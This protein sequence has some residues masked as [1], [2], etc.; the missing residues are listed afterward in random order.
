MLCIFESISRDLESCPRD[1]EDGKQGALRCLDALE[2]ETRVSSGKDIAPFGLVSLFAI[3][4]HS[5]SQVHAP[6]TFSEMF[7]DF[8]QD[9]K[10]LTFAADSQERP[11]SLALASMSHR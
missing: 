3:E 7:Q 2:Y 11:Q 1:L 5:H 10:A 4:H 6:S 8:K 9:M